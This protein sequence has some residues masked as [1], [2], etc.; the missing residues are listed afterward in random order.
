MEVAFRWRSTKDEQIRTFANGRPTLAASTHDLGFRDGVAAAVNAYVR[1]KQRQLAVSDPDLHAD[2]IAEGLTAVVSVKLD[3]P[4]FVGAT[5]GALGNTAV[6][7]C[8]EE[9]TRQH[10][11][12][13]LREH[14]KRAEAVL[15]RILHD[16][17]R[18]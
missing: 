9:A 3:H 5:R 10:L 13:W 11:G 2:R 16:V 18:D 15:D 4:E 7:A 12:R 6:R 14:P 17:R 1:E 8:V